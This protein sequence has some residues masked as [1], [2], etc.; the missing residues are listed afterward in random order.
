MGQVSQTTSEL[1]VRWQFMQLAMEVEQGWHT[2]ESETPV[3]IWPGPH[4]G[5]QK[6]LDPEVLLLYPS[7]QVLQ[8]VALSH[9][10]QLDTKQIK[11][12][13]VLSWLSA[14]LA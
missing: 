8:L 3:L 9:D 4:A 11:L 2:G 1:E 13:A 6:S 5:K 12:H 7:A 14:N 10:A